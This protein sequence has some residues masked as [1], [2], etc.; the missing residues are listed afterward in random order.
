MP[1]IS[2][3]CPTFNSAAFVTRTLE[4]VVSQTR[5][6]DEIII[7]DDGSADNTIS[8]VEDFFSRGHNDMNWTILRGEHRGAGATRNA[9]IKHSSG[10]W[11]AFIDSD[12]FWVPRKLEIICDAIQGNP[13]VNIFCHAEEQVGLDGS[14]HIID[15]GKWYDARKPLPAQIYYRSFFSPSA[16]TCQRKLLLEAGLF[17]ETIMSGLED[18]DLWQRMAPSARPHFI[19]IP[20]GYYMDRSGSL[21]FG[22]DWNKWKDSVRLAFR[23][24]H[25]VTP[26]GM[27][28]YISK[29]SAFYALRR[30]RRLLREALH[31]TSPISFLLL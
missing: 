29:V 10:E 4:S 21:V 31:K 5:K 17:D 19:S 8:V 6:P 25:R 18:F 23:Y 3:V 15:Y 30:I 9:G 28:Y 14:R 1:T 24:G 7:S 27:L 22:G 12:D 11:I 2:V 16:V 13:G 26:V 20:L